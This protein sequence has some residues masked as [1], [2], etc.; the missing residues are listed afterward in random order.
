MY[1][2]IITYSI[3]AYMYE[4]LTTG[5]QLLLKTLIW[6]QLTPI[7]ELCPVLESLVDLLTLTW[8]LED[9]IVR[10]LSCLLPK[11]RGGSTRLTFGKLKSS[12]WR[13]LIAFQDSD[14]SSLSLCL[15]LRV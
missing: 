3:Y 11:L 5:T 10:L 4:F 7:V 14:S 2:L 6:V 15:Q 12:G 9:L 8:L 13:T 1:I